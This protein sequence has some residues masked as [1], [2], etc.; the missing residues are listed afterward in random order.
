LVFYP[1][2]VAAE[3]GKVAGGGGSSVDY[4]YPVVDVAVD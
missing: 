3:G 2:V 1:V 4:G